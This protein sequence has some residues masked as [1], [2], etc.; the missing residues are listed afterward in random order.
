[1]PSV[2]SSAR[3][4]GRVSD[5]GAL[6]EKHMSDLELEFSVDA[7]SAAATLE[8]THGS[9]SESERSAL[10]REL[11]TAYRRLFTGGNFHPQTVLRSVPGEAVFQCSRVPGGDPR[12]PTLKLSLVRASASEPGAAP[13]AARSTPTPPHPQCWTEEFL[14]ALADVIAHFATTPHDEA[15]EAGLRYA[16]DQLRRD[17]TDAHGESVLVLFLSYLQFMDL[18]LTELDAP[19]AGLYRLAARAVER[20]SPDRSALSY[21]REP[22]CAHPDKDRAGKAAPSFRRLF[23]QWWPPAGC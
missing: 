20:L 15:E 10:C 6:L 7:A 13:G 5:L 8:V 23:Q 18:H 2:Q 14:Q 4:S 17:L 16:M 9:L 3:T 11:H 19:K 12:Q 1:M 22:L 21:T